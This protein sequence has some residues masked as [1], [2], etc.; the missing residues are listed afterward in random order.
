MWRFVAGIT[1]FQHFH[2]HVGSAHYRELFGD[3][4]EQEFLVTTF[5]MQCLF[6][7][8]VEVNF[9]PAKT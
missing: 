1:K 7:A 6:E 4:H 8:Q 3:I 5:L 9:D 2:V